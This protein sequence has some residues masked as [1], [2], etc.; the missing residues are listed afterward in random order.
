MTDAATVSSIP[1]VTITDGEFQDGSFQTDP[2]LQSE[3]Y[4]DAEPNN[5]VLPNEGNGANLTPVL[6][7]TTLEMQKT[8]LAVEMLMP[9]HQV[10]VERP[11]LLSGEWKFETQ[12]CHVD[13]VE[14]P[15]LN[16][17]CI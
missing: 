5:D 14:I 8:A 6:A 2:L 16:Y 3:N 1:L 9:V 11:S 13:R 12:I 7:G 15:S 10:N 17:I 4:I